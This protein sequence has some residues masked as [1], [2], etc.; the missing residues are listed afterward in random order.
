MYDWLPIVFGLM[1]SAGVV[2]FLYDVMRKRRRDKMTPS[3]A[4][5]Y[6]LTD[7]ELD[8]VLNYDIKYRMG[9][10]EEDEDA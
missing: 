10:S 4:A 3:L 6:E 8:Y 1:L 5:H 2:M 9:L 7:E